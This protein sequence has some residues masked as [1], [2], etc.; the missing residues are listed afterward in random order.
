PLIFGSPLSEPVAAAIGP[1]GRRVLEQVQHWAS[2][3]SGRGPEDTM[4]PGSGG[5][6]CTTTTRSVRS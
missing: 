4:P 5:A 1:L 2:E 6:R 3:D